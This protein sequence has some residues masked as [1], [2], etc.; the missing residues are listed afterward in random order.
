[1]PRCDPQSRCIS[2]SWLVPAIKKCISKQ[3][4]LI[5]NYGTVGSR[6]DGFEVFGH[7]HPAFL[8]SA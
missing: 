4:P 2:L 7:F 1:M 6:S 8:T 5:C 3:N